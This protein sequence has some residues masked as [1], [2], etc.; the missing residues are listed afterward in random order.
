MVGGT[1]LSRDRETEIETLRREN[2]R[3]R[4]EVAQRREAVRARRVEEPLV[5]SLDPD[6]TS[7]NAKP[8]LD[9]D[10]LAD[11]LED[12]I[13][14]MS[15]EL[16]AALGTGVQS[17]TSKLDDL[18]NATSED[19]PE[20]DRELLARLEQLSSEIQRLRFELAAARLGI[21]EADDEDETGEDVVSLS[22]IVIESGSAADRRH[23]QRWRRARRPWFYMPLIWGLVLLVVVL[24]ILL[25]WW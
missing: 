16:T 1:S 14:A 21:V 2:E 19:A 23:A 13:N 11:R 25:V 9:G 18:K 22:G 7:S 20:Y 12:V 10:R 15:V 17:I 4:R 24:V 5:P 6:H 8:G 3:L